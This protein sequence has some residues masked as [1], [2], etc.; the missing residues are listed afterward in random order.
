MQVSVSRPHPEIRQQSYGTPAEQHQLQAHCSKW[1]WNK[2]CILR[3][4]INTLESIELNQILW[5]YWLYKKKELLCQFNFVQFYWY[6]ICGTFHL[7]LVSW[8]D[9]MEL[10]SD[11]S[12]DIVINYKVIATHV[13]LCN[14]EITWCWFKGIIVFLKYSSFAVLICL[15]VWRDILINDSLILTR[16]W[17]FCRCSESRCRQPNL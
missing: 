8:F 2:L 14:F 5:G 7:S 4:Q 13:H 1:V 10:K 15:F 9:L 3:D 17:F 12:G 16:I 6:R 11:R